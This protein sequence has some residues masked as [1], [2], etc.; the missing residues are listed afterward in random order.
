MGIKNR[1][2]LKTM[3][4]ARWTPELESAR[5]R[6]RNEIENLRAEGYAAHSSLQKA[7][8]QYSKLQSKIAKFRVRGRPVDTFQ[9]EARELRD[10]RLAQEADATAITELHMQL[11]NKLQELQMVQ[12]RAG[13]KPTAIPRDG[14]KSFDTLRIILENEGKAYRTRSMVPDQASYYGDYDD[15]DPEE[16]AALIRVRELTRKIQAVTTRINT[17]PGNSGQY[18]AELNA[19]SGQLDEA[20]ANLPKGPK[21]SAYNDIINLQRTIK[22]LEKLKSEANKTF[23]VPQIDS[24]RARLDALMA[25][26]TP[27]LIRRR[28]DKL[29]RDLELLKKKRKNV[30]FGEG[31]MLDFEIKSLEEELQRLASNPAFSRGADAQKRAE[32]SAVR[33][34]IAKLVA[35]NKKNDIAIQTRIDALETRSKQLA[36]DLKGQ[37]DAG[38][39]NIDPDQTTDLGPIEISSSRVSQFRRRSR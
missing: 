13:A 11:T 35:Q 9:A 22:E 4:A 37:T 2:R 26:D 18:V 24:L 14:I 16:Q 21:N 20:K 12:R 10:L 29:A 1:N 32:L 15:T 17:D 34:E 8:E 27:I 3:A 33:Q 19:L 5:D 36:S 39:A 30:G 28:H 7:A 23:V 6:I 38:P 25:E 31:Y